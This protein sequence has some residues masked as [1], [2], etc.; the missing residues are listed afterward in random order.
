MTIQRPLMLKSHFLHLTSLVSIS[1]SLMVPTV[2]PLFRIIFPWEEHNS[3]GKLV[4]VGLQLLKKLFFNGTQVKH[5]SQ[6]CNFTKSSATSHFT[7][8]LKTMASVYLPKG[9]KAHL[10]NFLQLSWLWVVL[11]VTSV[12]TLFSSLLLCFTRSKHFMTSRTL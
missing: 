4:H 6:D 12:F 11:H 2:R 5:Q 10:E 7:S 3:S 8:W 1:S 9:W